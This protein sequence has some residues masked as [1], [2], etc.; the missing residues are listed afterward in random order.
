[1]GCKSVDNDTVPKTVIGISN[2]NN[3]EISKRNL[4]NKGA[5]KK[6]RKEGKV[7]GIYYSHDSNASVPFYIESKMLKEAYKSGARIFNIN[8]GLCDHLGA[9]GVPRVKK[10]RKRVLF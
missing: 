7:P 3:L 8:V 6:L 4:E 2:A 5:L 10:E 9:P 1:M